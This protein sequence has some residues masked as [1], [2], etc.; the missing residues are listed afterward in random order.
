MPFCSFCHALAQISSLFLFVC[1]FVLRFY[2]PV[3]PMGSCRA[4]SVYLTT[5]LLGRFSP[6]SGYP[7]LCTFFRQKLTTSLLESADGREWPQKIFHD[8][9]PR[10][11]VANLGGGWIRD[12][13]VSSR[14]AHPTEPPRP[15]WRKTYT[16]YKGCVYYCSVMRLES[17][18]RVSVR[19]YMHW[20]L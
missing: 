3:N 9:S 11:N 16:F 19:E 17:K 15:L 2:G 4:R 8:Q 13:L 6:L 14:T 20:R 5:R 1:L 10:K 18:A 7:V 12:L